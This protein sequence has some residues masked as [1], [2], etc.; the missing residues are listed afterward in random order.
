MTWSNDLAKGKAIEEIVLNGI[1]KNY[2]DAYRIEGNCKSWDI[3]IPT[4]QKGVEVKSDEKSQETG[5]ILVEISFGGIPSALATTR[6][7][8]WVFH[9]GLEFIWTTPERIVEMIRR[10]KLK[11]GSFTGKGD[12]KSKEAYFVK[13]EQIIFNCIEIVDITG[14]T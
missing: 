1:K 7:F 10:Y 11:A 2:P 3:Y 5:N 6:A 9:T 14:G 12:R 13:K 4:I 8:W